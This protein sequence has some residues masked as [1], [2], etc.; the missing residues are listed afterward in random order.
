MGEIPRGDKAANTA[1]GVF[2]R[3]CSNCKH[4]KRAEPYAWGK[5]EYLTPWWCESR[6]PVIHQ[7]Q[8][9]AKNCD[10]YSP[11]SD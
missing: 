5:C 11:T 10:C 7:T 9:N 2:K 6:G 4:W 1:P 8:N 3:T